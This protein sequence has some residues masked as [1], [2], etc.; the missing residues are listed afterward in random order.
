M[1]MTYVEAALL[2]EAT[3]QNKANKE[4]QEY[5]ENNG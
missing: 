5:V 1:V 4:W 3:D 2:Q